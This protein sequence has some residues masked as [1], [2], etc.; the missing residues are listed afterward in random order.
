MFARPK[1]YRC[2]PLHGLRTEKA[3]AVAVIFATSLVPITMLV[4]LVLN[5]GF[6]LQAKSKLDLA[7]DAAALAAVRT[8]AAGYAAGQTSANYLLEGKNAAAQ[9]WAA[10]AG[11]IPDVTASTATPTVTQNGQTFT[12]T[13]AYS[14]T[15]Y[16]AMPGIFN[17]KNPQTGAANAVVANSST[18]SIQVHAFG[19]VDFLLDNTSSMMLPA[20]DSNLALLQSGIAYNIY[21]STA[22]QNSVVAGAGSLIGW[23]GNASNPISV[24]LPKIQAGYTLAATSDYCAFACHWTTSGLDYY[25]VARAVGEKL[26]FDI[27]QSA[28]ETA[29]QEMEADEQVNGQ[30]SLG[31]FAFGGPAMGSSAYL[32]TIF[33]EAPL[34]PTVNGVSQKSIGGTNAINAMQGI[35]PP[36]SGDNPNTNI[37]EA[38]SLTL[39]ITGRGGNGNTSTTPLKSLI[40]VTDGLEDDN[41]TQAVPSTEGPINSAICDGF[42]QAG[43]TVYVLYTPYNSEPVYLPNGNFALQP[44][45]T[46]ATAPSILSA[47]QACASSPTDVI[48]A[49]AP[50]D[51]QAGMTTLIDEAVGSTTRL[52]N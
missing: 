39:D 8:A 7:A 34:D 33:A 2:A 43:Y 36:L 9:W 14:A 44:Y 20:D 4:G 29:I 16:E 30:L 46:G 35:T 45:I 11:T 47:L 24:T 50:A 52:T 42:K 1:Q 38:L 23:N 18:A 32:K 6:T 25:A 41:N 13:I 27:V 40:L 49:T 15:V 10:Q 31:I 26:R 22:F 5:F 12:A 17:W 37:G 3:A 51:I 48:Q 21:A 19:T 28:T